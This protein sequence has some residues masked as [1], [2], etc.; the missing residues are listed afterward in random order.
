MKQLSSYMALAVSGG[1]RISFTYD[2]I[3]DETGDVESANNKVSF[4][5]TD[6]SLRAH[7]EAVR[8]W[9]REHKLAD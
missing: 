5:V 8:D 4:F 6:E 2:V 1:D 9:I 7:I 3:N